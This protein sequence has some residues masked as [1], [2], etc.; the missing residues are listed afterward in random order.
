MSLNRREFIR[1]TAAAA[2]IAAMAPRLAFAADG[3]PARGTLV[4]IFQRGGMDGLNAVV[5]HGDAD[6]YRLRPTIAVP[7]PGV[8]N[9]ALDLDGLKSRL[10]KLRRY[11]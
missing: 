4:V 1:N 8:G 10:S 6:Y 5:P 3:V 7:R 9:G 2:A 11:L